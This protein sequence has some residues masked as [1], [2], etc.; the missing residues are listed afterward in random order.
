MRIIF[1]ITFLL[2]ILSISAQ[3]KASSMA[4]YLEIANNSELSKKKDNA[5]SFECDY[6]FYESLDGAKEKL[7]YSSFFQKNDSKQIYFEQ[8][9]RVTIQNLKYK[10]IL[11]TT[12]KTL[13]FTDADSVFQ[14]QSL[15]DISNYK[16]E[17]NNIKK[18]QDQSRI[19]FYFEL[20]QGYKYSAYEIWYDLKN[21]L[22]KVILYASQE[23]DNGDDQG[24]LIRPRME[25][26]YK[27]YNYNSVKKLKLNFEDIL[28][29]ENDL[30]IVKEKY[31]AFELIDLRKK[32]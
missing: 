16:K 30:I 27:N 18:Y 20:P 6:L 32:I 10:I 29:L 19:K 8:F 26:L 15:F 24:V 13:V 3:W 31:K 5:F 14:D 1:S 25:I 17:T 11:D 2:T 12:E 4:E 7:K 28:S 22:E 23:I 21:N 9:G